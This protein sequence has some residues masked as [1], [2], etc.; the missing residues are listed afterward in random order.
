M[1]AVL[2]SRVQKI[3]TYSWP[4]IGRSHF[5]N[6]FFRGNTAA[7]IVFAVAVSPDS[8]ITIP[9][10]MKLFI[11][12]IVIFFI[13]F[14]VTPNFSKASMCG[15]WFFSSL[16]PPDLYNLK[17]FSRAAK[18]PIKKRTPWF[19]A[20]FLIDVRQIKLS[21]CIQTYFPFLF[22][23]FTPGWIESQASLN[24]L[25]FRNVRKTRHAL[26]II[27]AY[28]IERAASLRTEFNFLRAIF[29]PPFILNMAYFLWLWAVIS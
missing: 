27:P 3:C 5:D 26:I 12:N 28:K 24:F 18:A 15:G 6:R 23:T 21:A 8:Y 11:M 17:L 10:R 1:P 20:D 19:F 14:N 4:L 7:I 2:L 25:R 29:S 22:L 13:W 9:G 16:Q